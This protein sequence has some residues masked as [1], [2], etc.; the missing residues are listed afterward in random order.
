MVLSFRWRTSDAPGAPQMRETTLFSP[1]ETVGMLRR[2]LAQECGS[3]A[4]AAAAAAGPELWLCNDDEEGTPTTRRVARAILKWTPT[5]CPS[6]LL[7]DYPSGQSQ[8]V[9]LFTFPPATTAAPAPAAS[10]ASVHVTCAFSACR[11]LL[12]GFICAPS[13]R[14]SRCWWSDS[15]T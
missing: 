13:S 1:N 10:T 15:P 9:I 7:E 3:S 8:A 4:A 12:T 14:T 6:V 11:T 5:T 2:R